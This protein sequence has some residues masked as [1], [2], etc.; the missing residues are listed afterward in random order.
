MSSPMYTDTSDG[1]VFESSLDGQDWVRGDNPFCPY[2]RVRFTARMLAVGGTRAVTYTE[3]YEDVLLQRIA[4]RDARIRTLED[5]IA[6]PMPGPSLVNY[7]Q[8][9]DWA[10]DILAEGAAIRK[11]REGI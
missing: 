10:Q 1:P 5:L 6:K 11:R 4:D 2:K 9:H 3:R 8:M 7:Q